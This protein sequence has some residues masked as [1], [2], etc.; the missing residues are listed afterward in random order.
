MNGE[1]ANSSDLGKIFNL[2]LII[3]EAS[4]GAFKMKELKL[5]MIEYFKSEKS[6]VALRS[7]NLKEESWRGIRMKLINLEIFFTLLEYDQDEDLKSEV[8]ISED[9]EKIKSNISWLGVLV[10]DIFSAEKESKTGQL[11]FNMI[12]IRMNN[13]NIDEEQ[14]IITI[15]NEINMIKI[16]NIFL[17]DKIQSKYPCYNIYFESLK[18]IIEGYI[19]SCIKSKRYKHL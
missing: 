13:K 5:K 2:M 8:K 14:S 19:Y 10:N 18:Q 16:M 7:V 3:G 1:S 4:L 17:F 15:I 12:K 6:C 9:L 11:Q